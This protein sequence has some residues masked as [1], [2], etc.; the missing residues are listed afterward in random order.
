MSGLL[1]RSMQFIL[2]ELC[3][4]SEAFILKRT[5]LLD[6]AFEELKMWCQVPFTA[7]CLLSELP[8]SC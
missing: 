3:K 4:V 2:P 6:L 1:C 7:Y 5:I 8:I